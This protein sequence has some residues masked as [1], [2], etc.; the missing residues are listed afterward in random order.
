MNSAWALRIAAI[1]G[2]AA[3]AL[4]AFGA[5]GLK[6]ILEENQTAAA[7]HTAVLYHFIHAV[8]LFILAQ[9]QPF[10]RGPW[11]CFVAGILLFSGS[12]YLLALTKAPWLGPLTPLGGI[13]FLVGWAWLAKVRS[14]N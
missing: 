5:H 7:W 11:W 9:R 8:M 13:S 1:L 4:G 14:E 10:A 2:F 3:V 6:R 12:L